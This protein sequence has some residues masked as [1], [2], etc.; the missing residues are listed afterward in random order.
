MEKMTPVNTK[1]L[2]L[3]LEKIEN[4]AEVDAKPPTVIKL[5]GAEGKRKME[6]IDS[7]IPEH[8]N[9][10]ALVISCVLYVRKMA[11]HTNHTTLVTVVNSIPTVL[12]SKGMGLQEMH[13]GMDILIRTFQIRETTKQQ[14]LLRLFTRKQRKCPQAVLQ[15]QEVSHEGLRK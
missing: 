3:I 1:A 4:N 9:M 5:K 11:G 6:L 15:G 13:K 12:L 2:L 8:L 10:Y 7:R 14:I